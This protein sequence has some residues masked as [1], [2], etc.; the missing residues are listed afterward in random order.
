[1]S[2]KNYFLNTMVPAVFYGTITGIITGAVIWGYQYLAEEVL[3]AGNMVYGYV[4]SHLAFLPLLIVGLLIAGLISYFNVKLTPEVRGGGVPYIEGAARGIL[5]LKW[6]KVV[7]AAILGSFLSFFCGLPLGSEGPSVLI[8]GSLGCGVNSLG[9]KYDKKR[10]AWNRMAITGGASAGFATALG[11]PLA[12]ILF[13][14]EEC[15][16]KFSPVVLLTSAISVLFAVITSGLLRFWTGMGEHALFTF[17]IASLEITQLYL[18]IIAGV[19]AGFAAIGFSLLLCKVAPKIRKIKIPS[20]VRTMMVYLISGLA[21]LLFLDLIGGGAG[22]IQKVGD[23]ALE[24]KIILALLAIKLVLLVFCASA[25]LCGGMFIPFLCVGALV[26]GLMAKLM[27][28]CGMSE[29]YYST[30]VVITMCAFLGSVLE[31]PITAVILIVELAG[32]SSLLVSLI[33]IVGAYIVTQLFHMK[34]VYDAM[35]ENIINN[36]VR[37]GKEVKTVKLEITALEGSYAIGKSLID[38]LFPTVVTTVVH[39]DD[40]QSGS[41]QFVQGNRKINVGDVI[42]VEAHTVDENKLKKELDYLFSSPEEK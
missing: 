13:A 8:G 19:V 35:L 39:K 16:K 2:A 17:E 33:S 27:V 32:M 34:P 40:L 15:H 31:A 6:Y 3:S 18:P 12:G 9:G 42:I 4:Q 23:M 30:I 36:N 7:P 25:D 29:A 28:V 21:C 14:L 37:A 24:W 41:K 1:M 20:L 26:G 5:P 38:I 22:I 11:A 10:N